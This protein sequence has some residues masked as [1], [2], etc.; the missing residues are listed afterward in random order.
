MQVVG[1]GIETRDD[2]DFLS[3]LGCDIGQG[4]FI[5]RPMPAA[6][7]VDWISAWRTR[8]ALTA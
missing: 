3:Q 5:A 8:T 2:W 1:E 4:Y 6:D 7:I